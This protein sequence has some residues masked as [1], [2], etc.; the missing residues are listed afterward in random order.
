MFHETPENDQLPC[1]HSDY[2]LGD[3]EN[4]ADPIGSFYAVHVTVNITPDRLFAIGFTPES[5]P[6]AK[7]HHNRTS[8]LNSK[9]PNHSRIDLLCLLPTELS[10]HLQHTLH[11]SQ[12]HNL[13]TK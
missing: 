3:A 12:N 10:S 4:Y 1:L 2:C 13:K 6:A 9:P 7:P 5:A 8:Q 11:T